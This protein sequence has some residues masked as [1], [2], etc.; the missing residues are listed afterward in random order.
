MAKISKIPK[1][2]ATA[3]QLSKNSCASKNTENPCGEWRKDRS[4]IINN[5][6]KIILIGNQKKTKRKINHS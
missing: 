5:N 3:I 2:V 4:K 6:P 1:M